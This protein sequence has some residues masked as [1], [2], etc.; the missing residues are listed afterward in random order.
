MGLQTLARPPRQTCSLDGFIAASP[1]LAELNVTI[2][3][4][5]GYHVLKGNGK[6]SIILSRDAPGGLPEDGAYA[7]EPCPVPSG[8]CALWER[9]G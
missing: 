3:A 1:H 7:G 6:S 4:A 9:R 8:F 5:L 2:A